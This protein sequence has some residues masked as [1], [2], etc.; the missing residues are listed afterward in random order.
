MFELIHSKRFDIFSLENKIIQSSANIR[1]PWKR[2]YLEDYKNFTVVFHP[3]NI[4]IQVGKAGLLTF[5]QLNSE[6]QKFEEKKQSDDS[7]EKFDWESARRRYTTVFVDK[8]IQFYLTAMIRKCYDFMALVSLPVRL[9]DKLTKDITG[10]TARKFSRLPKFELFSQLFRT[11]FINSSLIYV[12]SFTY[13]VLYNISQSIYSKKYPSTSHVIKWI[14][15]KTFV[16]LISLVAASIGY[17]FGSYIHPY[18][19]SN[20][21]AL[22]LESVCTLSAS[23]MTGLD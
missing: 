11:Y 5:L 6:L 17:S 4:G 10:S 19:G 21:L 16:Y 8:S 23:Y 15:K 2:K 12:S 18:F 7:N 1:E 9:T 14:G 20:A 22:V 13:D 3:K